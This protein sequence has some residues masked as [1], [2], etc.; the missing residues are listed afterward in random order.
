MQIFL[1]TRAC[2]LLMIPTQHH[3]FVIAVCGMFLALI[4]PLVWELPDFHNWVTQFFPDF[5]FCCE[6]KN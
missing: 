3:D 1:W 2:D 4:C 6:T 5:V